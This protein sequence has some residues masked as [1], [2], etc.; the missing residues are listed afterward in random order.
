MISIKQ[1]LEQSAPL[2]TPRPQYP[3]GISALDTLLGGGLKAGQ[4]LEFFGARSA[5]K[6][7][8]VFAAAKALRLSGHSVLWIDMH[9]SLMPANLTEKLPGHLWVIHPPQPQ[10]GL[11]CAEVMLKTQSFALIVLDGE[12]LPSPKQSVRLQRFARQSGTAFILLRDTNRNQPVSSIN[13]RVEFS[14]WVDRVD[15]ELAKRHPFSWRVEMTHR[16]T[17]SPGLNQSLHLSEGAHLSAY[18]PVQ[19]PDRSIRHTSSPRSARS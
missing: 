15:D 2:R 7:G 17:Q 3:I 16:G 9:K 12:N 11:F 14:T 10:D 5:G 8:A 1:L 6:S 19:S 13:A 4:T 18:V